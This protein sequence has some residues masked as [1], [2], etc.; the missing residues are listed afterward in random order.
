MV[1]AE[2]DGDPRT[3][4]RLGSTL[5]LASRARPA[6]AALNSDHN[7]LEAT[8]DQRA[9]PP[10]HGADAV[11]CARIARRHARTFWLASLLLPAHKRR[12]AFA[13]YSFCRAADDSV[14]EG[15]S[16][17]RAIDRSRRRLHQACEGSAGD[18]VGRELTLALVNFAIPRA[19]LDEL[20]DGV[21]RDLDHTGYETWD[22][23]ELY[24]AGV[25][26]SVGE[27]TMHVLGLTDTAMQRNAV[28]C[29]RRLGIAMQLTNVLRDVG[30]D[31]QRGRCY[32]P[33]A[34]LALVGLGADAILSR[35]VRHGSGQWRAFMQAQIRRA[36]DIYRRARPGIELLAPDARPCAR[37]C[38]IGYE[39]ILDAIEANN[40][41][42]FTR[43]ASL[44]WGARAGVVIR[45]F[46][47]GRDAGTASQV[48][49]RGV[50]P[51]PFQS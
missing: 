47:P 6:V 20:L 18:P 36:R 30:E 9:R 24:C 50:G 3:R 45:A 41:D 11:H 21:A 10:A 8:I 2:I 29:A 27:M 35:Q 17:G 5:R 43:R 16:D 51:D 25:A 42:V 15:R 37:A 12:A 31:A 48:P 26:S 22:E 38:A 13:L 46:L 40:Y 39:G 33:R 7:A 19:P 14:D 44:G 4:R 32:L 49:L 28:E 34:E 23:L 1:S